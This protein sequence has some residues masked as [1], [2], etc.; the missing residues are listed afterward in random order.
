[1]L[2]TFR[3]VTEPFGKP[4]WL[5]LILLFLLPL[6]TLLYALPLQIP[7][8]TLTIILLSLLIAVVNALCEEVL[9]RGLYFE[10]FPE[11]IW[12]GYLYP[13]LWFGLWHYAPQSV[14]ASSYPGGTH[15]LVL[16][17]LVLGLM[18][19]WVAWKTKSI[20]WTALAHI[21]LDFSG[22]GALFYFS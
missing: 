4:R 19:G 22:L 13:A 21:I 5:G 9:W 3:Q 14:L 18:W 6:F 16:F 11:S 7:R 2:A 17:A 1:M 10:S 12:W 15:S 8:A 20:R